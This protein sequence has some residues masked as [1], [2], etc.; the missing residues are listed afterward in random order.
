MGSVFTGR[1]FRARVP[2]FALAMVGLA[3]LSG[4]RPPADNTL[5]GSA[6]LEVRVPEPGTTADAS[7]AIAG[8]G[9]YLYVR[10]LGG[11]DGDVGTFWGPLSLAGKSVII[12]DIETG[13]YSD[14]FVLHASNDIG[15][16]TFSTWQT[17]SNPG[18][19][20]TVSLQTLME[21]P[22][23]IFRDYASP[24]D[25]NDSIFASPVTGR[26]S[27]ALTGSVTIRPGINAFSL[28]LV[29]L[30]TSDTRRELMDNNG[31]YY[32]TTI[33]DESPGF[34][35]LSYPAEGPDWESTFFSM[36]A[37]NHA[38]PSFFYA[39]NGK[40][41]SGVTF[42]SNDDTYR[43]TVATS[44]F[45]IYVYVG[46]FISPPYFAAYE[47]GV[48][49]EISITNEAGVPLANGGDHWFSDVT[50]SSQASPADLTIGN[51]GTLP[52]AISS[53]VFSGANPG[54]FYVVQGAPLTV[55]PQADKTVTVVFRYT[56]GAGPREA[57][58][59]INSTSAADGSFAILLH[60]AVADE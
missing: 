57:T 45:P 47:G 11:P 36:Y 21:Y 19:G 52:L 56:A 37:Y 2:A 49:A 15:E 18:G 10:A 3:L 29:P 8:A 30:T 7:R 4:C 39:S 22:D 13:T 43:G 41:I 54:N 32:S 25:G 17:A 59:T 12:S 23:A 31:F 46:S 1:L 35:R 24:T 28:T 42:D 53:F 34:Y 48:P 33:A 60:G 27:S 38:I 5:A 20:G 55:P 9:G 26:G 14:F 16:N 51:G 6:R 40:R 58:L 50:Y 44:A